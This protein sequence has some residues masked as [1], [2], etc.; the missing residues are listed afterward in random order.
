M[1][2]AGATAL[3]APGNRLIGD[4]QHVIGKSPATIEVNLLVSMAGISGALKIVDVG[5]TARV[6]HAAASR[7][8]PPWWY[9]PP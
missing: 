8:E 9:S 4:L 2:G 5:E 7:T 6:Q 3:G 1:H